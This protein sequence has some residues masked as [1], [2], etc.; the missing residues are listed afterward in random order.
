MS[1]SCHVTTWPA[2]LERKSLT[3]WARPI[4]SAPGF[5]YSS[6]IASHGG[7]WSLDNLLAFLE[8]PKTWAPGTKMTFKGMP[9]LEDRIDLIVYRNQADGTPEPLAE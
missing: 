6:G 5:K 1:T 9:D 2:L 7:D 3:P 8:A 4:G